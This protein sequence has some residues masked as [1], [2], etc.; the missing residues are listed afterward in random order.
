MVDAP[1]SVFLWSAMIKAYS[2]HDD[3][4]LCAEALLLYSRMHC[5][6]LAGEQPLTYTLLSSLKACARL[7]ALPQGMQLHTHVFKYNFHSDLCV[8][9][10]LIQFCSA[11]GCTQQMEQVL[12]GVAV[13]ERD[14][15]AWNTM[16]ARYAKMGDMSAALI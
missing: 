9:T 10:T 13:A 11:C 3:A 5:S 6:L 16:I 14:V 12:D 15:Q 8:Q 2:G 4:F 1:P 7:S